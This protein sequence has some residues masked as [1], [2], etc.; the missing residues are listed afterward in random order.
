MNLPVINRKIKDHHSGLKEENSGFGL[1]WFGL[2]YK[3]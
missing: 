1:D 3:F 2:G